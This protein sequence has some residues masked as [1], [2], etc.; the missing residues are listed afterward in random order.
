MAPARVWPRVNASA[1]NRDARPGGWRGLGREVRRAGFRRRC[2]SGSVL[3][4]LRSTIRPPG[5][6]AVCPCQAARMTRCETWQR[7]TCAG[8]MEAPTNSPPKI[9]PAIRC[10]PT[11]RGPRAPDEAISATGRD[12]FSATR[13]RCERVFGSLRRR[14]PR[15]AAN[16][17]GTWP[18]RWHLPLRAKPVSGSAWAAICTIPNRSFAPFSTA[19]MRS[20]R[21]CGAHRS[22]TSCSGAG[23]MRATS[24]TR[25]GPSRRST[26]WSAH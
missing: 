5:R 25:P 20:F 1:R 22:W 24:T 26:R 8:S 15:E 9:R 17:P 14:T 2:P 7:A 23:T 21:R 3:R 18:G 12:W 11:W 10:W 16:R 6:R 13:S 19:A 4:R